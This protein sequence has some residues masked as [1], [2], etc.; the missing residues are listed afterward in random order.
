MDYMVQRKRITHQNPILVTR[1]T[2]KRKRGIDSQCKK[3]KNNGS[4]YGRKAQYTSTSAKKE[5]CI[6]LFFKCAN[7]LGFNCPIEVLAQ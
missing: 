6:L 4:C 1:E 7:K 3:Q 2:I 5:F